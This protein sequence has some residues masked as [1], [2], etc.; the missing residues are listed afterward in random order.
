MRLGKRGMEDK[1]SFTIWEIIVILIVIIT[2]TLAV[3]GIT[4]NSSYWKKYHSADLA[5]MTDLLFV[6]QGDL[7]INYD[8]KELQKNFITKTMHIEPLVFQVFLKDNSYFV[9][10]KSIDEDRFPKSYIFAESD[11]M[12][13]TNSDMTS[14]YIVLYKTGDTISMGTRVISEQI[15]CSAI[16]TSIPDISIKRFDA[17]SLPDNPTVYVDYVNS[18]LRSLAA[19]DDAE[20]LIVLRSNNEGRYY[21]YYD[22]VSENQGNSEKMSC[23]VLKQLSQRYPDS[24][25]RQL[26]YDNS[27]EMEPF[28][29][30]R[31]NHTFWI[32]IDVDE[33][34]SAKDLSDSI[35]GALMEYYGIN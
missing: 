16:D 23:L 9:Y 27:L 21:A 4:N 26:L 30:E 34:I 8:M 3:R 19:G 15:S 33:S 29:S 7:V 2:L 5:L 12:K 35:V 14:D 24:D 10:D 13:V 28:T 20:V 17:I 31:D 6:G 22:S 25:V 1:L 11:G 18:R 32:I